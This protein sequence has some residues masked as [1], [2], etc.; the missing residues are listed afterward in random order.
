M[1]KETKMLKNEE[2]KKTRQT[3]NQGPESRRNE[4]N[5]R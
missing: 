1:A 2:A 4:K 3:G 5:C